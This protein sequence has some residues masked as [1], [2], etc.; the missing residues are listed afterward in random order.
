MEEIVRKGMRM[1]KPHEL[2]LSLRPCVFDWLVDVS[3]DH[4]CHES[5]LARGIIEDAYDR[6]MAASPSE[7]V[8]GVE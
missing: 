1:R 7:E 6:A 4:H 5:V 3:G 8:T 2:K